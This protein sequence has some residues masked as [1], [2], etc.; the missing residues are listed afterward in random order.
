[1]EGR[2]SQFQKLLSVIEMG[3][4][5]YIQAHDFPDHDAIASA[6][7]LS[8][9]LARND[10]E[11]KIVYSGEIRRADLKRMIKELGV[12]LIKASKINF[13]K[14]DN[15][16]LVDSCIGNKNVTRLNGKYIAIIDHHKKIEIKED[17]PFLDID[18][19]L[20]SCSSIIFSYFNNI[21]NIDTKV[22]TALMIGINIDTRNMS[23]GVNTQDLYA[24][25]NLYFRSDIETVNSIV[26]NH[27]TISD[28]KYFKYA[29]E[30][31]ATYKEIGF[32]FF[33]FKFDINLLGIIGDFF[34]SVNEISFVLLCME[35][36]NEVLFSSRNENI[37]WSSAE[38][39]N[40]ILKDK[41][42]GG[43]HDHMAGGIIQNKDFFNKNEIF[44]TLISNLY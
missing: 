20:G 22:A 15:I 30:N 11:S 6:F 40:I 14:E 34:L 44:E 25:Y 28:L 10:I 41:G 4:K 2:T 32:C 17:I 12:E 42:F 37:N 29:I 18:D 8:Y 43:G 13:D 36:E 31:I 35:T 9:L 27:I 1:M 5:I 19:T 16:I 26:R 33:P 38:I 21:E 7:S 3:S 23:R 24:F 39:I